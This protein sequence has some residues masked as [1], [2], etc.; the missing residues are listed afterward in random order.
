MSYC[1]TT[2]LVNVTGC[3]LSSTILQAVIDDGDREIDAYLALYG[4]SGTASGAIKSASLKLAKAGLLEYGLQTGT[5]QAAVPDYTS[6]VNVTEAVKA[7]REQAF[8]LVEQY[9]DAQ[10]SLSS[11]KV[12]FVRRVDGRC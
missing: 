8:A 4:L 5:M 11:T 1:S 3:S 2:E 7:L 10:V 9:K 6:S 12:S